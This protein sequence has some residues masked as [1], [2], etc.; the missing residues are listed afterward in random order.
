MPSKASTAES[1]S[2]G[3]LQR[4]AD[5]ELR[6]ILIGKARREKA[7][8][9]AA[10]SSALADP[11]GEVH[12]PLSLVRTCSAA[13]A[14]AAKGYGARLTDEIFNDCRSALLVLALGKSEAPP[15]RCGECGGTATRWGLIPDD[16]GSLVYVPRC[17]RHG[18]GPGS[19]SLIGTDRQGMPR[20]G[21]VRLPFLVA[22]AQGILRQYAENGSPTDGADLDREPAA[23][24]WGDDLTPDELLPFLPSQSRN[25]QVAVAAALTQQALADIGGDHGM[26][27]E[28][29]K[30][31][32]QRGAAE[33]A[34][35]MSRQDC[36][37]AVLRALGEA[38]RGFLPEERRS[39]A[40]EAMRAEREP[41]WISAAQV[42]APMPRYLGKGKGSARG[43][44]PVL[45]RWGRLNLPPLSRLGMR[46]LQLESQRRAHRLYR[47]ERI[48]R[49][50]RVLASRQPD[51]YATVQPSVPRQPT[52]AVPFKGKVTGYQ[53][54]PLP[55]RCTYRPTI[56]RSASIGAQPTSAPSQLRG[57]GLPLPD[58]RSKASRRKAERTVAKHRHNVGRRTVNGHPL[59]PTTCPRTGQPRLPWLQVIADARAA[60]RVV[61]LPDS[62]RPAGAP[63]L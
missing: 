6:R 13:T 5:D 26:K 43:I 60:G 21:A 11:E 17:Y 58:S 61:R 1:R 57:V 35:L 7:E 38:E 32:A 56:E 33:L 12:T 2:I 59:P 49:M 37:E 27:R 42:L 36:R 25:V 10:I 28:T 24:R 55:S 44:G 46:K 40:E 3:E 39:A 52:Q 51:A 8:Q 54:Q 16:Y 30:K 34:A 31:A 22:H 4:Q 23:S 18:S 47:R 53:R 50:R 48:R 15:S 45:I 63:R 29:A 14:L 20:T 19:R 41:L 9:A 62:P